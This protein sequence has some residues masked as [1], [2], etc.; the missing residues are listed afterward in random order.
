MQTQ[1][2]E[3]DFNVKNAFTWFMFGLTAINQ[4]V[5]QTQSAMVRSTTMVDQNLGSL[6]LNPLAGGA[7]FSSLLPL[8]N[9]PLQTGQNPSD[10]ILMSI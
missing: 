10:G 6:L 3:H 7:P 8:H 2:P 4:V 1:L 5:A 9:K